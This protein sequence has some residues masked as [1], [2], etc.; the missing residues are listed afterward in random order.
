LFLVLSHWNCLVPGIAFGTLPFKHCFAL[1]TFA[2]TRSGAAQRSRTRSVQHFAR[3]KICGELARGARMSMNINGALSQGASQC[4]G[5]G[6]R[7][8]LLLLRASARCRL[9]SK[10]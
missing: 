1:V 10:V 9:K 7:S 8:L 2:A 6:Q 3:L 5:S 4:A